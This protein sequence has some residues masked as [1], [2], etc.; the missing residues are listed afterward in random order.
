VHADPVRLSQ[1]FGNLLN[2]AGKYTSRGGRITVTAERRGHDAIVAVEDN[3]MGIPPDELDSIFDMFAQVDRSVE[4]SQGGLGIGLTLVKR[5][6]QM[7]GGSVEARSE[8]EDRG[9]RF[10]VRLPAM[11][12]IPASVPQGPPAAREQADT[13]R[14]L[15][16]DDNRDAAES[17]AMLLSVTGHDTHVVHDGAAALEAVAT[18]RPDVVLLDIGLPGLN[19][20]EVCRRV[21]AQDWA[22]GILII[23]LTGWGQE[24]DRRKTREAGFDGHMVKPVDYEALVALLRTLPPG[25]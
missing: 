5:L 16:V 1:V 12:E 10:V 8:G 18:H 7:H 13:R 24:E 6:V 9:S 23:A 2:N 14:I 3:G 20:Y 4:R 22:R 25:A 11:M 17:L 19:G 21:R 15:V